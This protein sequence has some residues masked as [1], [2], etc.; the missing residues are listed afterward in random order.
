MGNYLRLYVRSCQCKS[1]SEERF[2]STTE[3]EEVLVLQNAKAIGYE[4]HDRFQPLNFNHLKLTFENYGRWHA[5][6]IAYRDQHPE[7]FRKRFSDLECVII[8]LLPTLKS[9]IDNSEQTLYAVLDEQ[10]E[11]DLKKR[12][13]GLLKGSIYESI[14]YYNS[15]REENCIVLHGDCWNNNFMFKYT[16][17]DKTTPQKVIFLDFQVSKIGSPVL[18]LSYHFYSTASGSEHQY[19]DTLL[20]IYHNSLSSTIKQLGSDPD[21]LFPYEELIRQWKEYSLFG[22]LL[23]MLIL[24]VALSEKEDTF[25]IESMTDENINNMFEQLKKKNFTRLSSRMI[26]VVKHFLGNL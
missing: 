24:T 9:V 26:N 7:E 6:G 21:K 4:L 3:N 12:F 5:F 10:G 22:C 19:F 18:D 17:D 15:K 13:K 1:P 20:R 2:S 23:A 11:L 25:D 8:A 14:L 16:D